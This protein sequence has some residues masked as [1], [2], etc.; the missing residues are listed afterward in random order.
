MLRRTV[1]SAMVTGALIVTLAGFANAQ[2]DDG[3]AMT[4]ACGCT[5]R[6]PPAQVEG[7]YMGPVV[8]PVDGVGTLVV[9]ITQKHRHVSG[10]WSLAFSSGKQAG[11]TLA[12]TVSAKAI[13]AKLRTS[14]PHCRYR[15]VASVLADALDG[16]I[17]P[18]KRCADDN[19]DT[20][21]VERQ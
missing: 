15:L 18:S 6:P 9:T 12:G 14:D 13:R 2:T 5:H 19:P 3:D 4:A 7:S 21:T 11:G 1:L 20:F 8:D 17:D 10:T 16:T